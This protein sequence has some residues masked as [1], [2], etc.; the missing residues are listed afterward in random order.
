MRLPLTLPCLAGRNHSQCDGIKCVLFN[1]DKH[2]LLHH[3]P[4]IPNNISL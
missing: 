2:K 4:S 1:T 3:V